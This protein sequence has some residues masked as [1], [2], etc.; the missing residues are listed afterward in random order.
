MDM[1][2]KDL[3]LVAAVINKGTY[4]TYNSRGRFGSLLSMF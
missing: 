3:K 1:L 2:D 4:T